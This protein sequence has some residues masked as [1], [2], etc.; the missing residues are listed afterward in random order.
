[1]LKR[2]TI[3]FLSLFA[4]LSVWAQ[5]ISTAEDFV[6][7]AQAISKGEPTTI[8]RNDDG[9]VCLLADIDMAKVRKFRGIPEFKGVFNG[10][11]FSIKNLKCTEP[12]FGR[13]EGGTV[14]N[15]T[16]DASCSMKLTD[17]DN[18]YGFIAGVNAGLIEDCVNY[19]KIEFKST[20]V[21]RRLVIGGIAGSNLHLVI[22]CRNYGHISAD[23]LSRTDSEKPAVSIGGIVG[24]NGGSR[25]ASCVAWSENSGTV[26]Y[27]G[28][29][30][31]DSVG[32]IVGDGNAGT[33]KFCVNR[34][35]VMSNASGSNGWDIYSRCA[36]IVGYTKGDVLCCDNFG[37]I[38]SQGNGIPSTAGVVGAMN[39]ADVI[40][41]CVN[42]GLVKVS[43]EREGSM[44]GICATV[45][46]SARVKSCLNYGDVV[47][48]GV[49]TKRRT[50]VGGIVGYLYN[51]KDAVTGGYIRDCA[52]Y[53]T[54]KSGKGG[55]RYENDD[56]A[57]HTGGI[58][59]YVRGSTAYR[60]ILSNCSNFGKV[61]SAGG[62]RGNIAGACQDVSIGG[63][64]INPYTES[65][66][67]TVA[68]H[69]VMGCVRSEDGTP[70]SG[71]LVSD[72][73]QT[74]Q[75][76]T[77]GYYLMKSDMDKIRFVYI[78]VPAAY[79]I[80]VSGSSPQF[81]R[82]VPRYQKAVKADF[83]LSPREEVNEKYT[84]LLVADPQI[85]PYAVDGSAETWRDD[86][87]T[88][89]NAYHATLTQ[90]CY[91]INLGDLIYNYPVAYDDYMDVAAGLKCPVFNVIGNHD[92]DQRNL[93]S[94]S[95][96]TPY[97]NVYTGPE[98]YSF[99]IGKIHYV[100]LNDII[101]D[102][103][104]AKDKYK[105][106]LE[107]STLEWLR[108]DL[109]FI[110][111][112]NTIVIAAHG[113]L[114]MSPK[115]NGLGNPNFE[116]YSDLLKDYAKVYCWAGHYHSNFGY[117]YAGK[118][119]GLDNIEAIC[120]SRATGSLRVNR[121]LN[122]HGTPQGYMVAEVDGIHM[123]WR[124]KAVGRT[125]DEQMTAYVPSEVDGKNVAVNVWNWNEDTWGV[126]EWWEN[127]RK[128]ADMESWRA[129]DPAYLK[130]I[131]DITDKYTL[132]LAQPA[133]SRYLFRA[134][135]SEGVTS[136]E[137]RVKDNFGNIFTKSITW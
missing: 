23:C 53:G 76:G 32:G 9:E 10:N 63:A 81:Y 17:G 65:A 75:T 27:I 74:V 35:E 36:G 79:Q 78:S 127:G 2:L 15:L 6:A 89:I 24:R 114:F 96:G 130:L 122:N 57:I 110:S 131:S 49:S 112:E 113:Q 105:V 109:Q 68:G 101:Y 90:E 55:N 16:I 102:R 111:K 104:S 38:S 54:V 14:R 28:D 72:G 34:G 97:F 103:T 19:G 100:V 126:P 40:L 67:V 5:G 73:F 123:S 1:M 25:W 116:K 31:Y 128:V 20:F 44:G 108:Q 93:Y 7:F 37:Y 92:F 59:G 85:R 13:I 48:E 95:L 69:N 8:W 135:P 94:T 86:V 91:A 47:Y 98:N 106:G 124:Y 22:R 118:G 3:S 62:R 77:D 41:D 43:N 80:P 18:L 83:V 39:D 42:Y 11:G 120:V 125:M 30:M 26:T 129:K 56:K 45:S 115:G 51:A 29:M 84:L 117:D 121:Y 12:I 136:G 52:N 71:V 66:E 87:A 88:D 132:E 119:I 134:L 60:V 82:R 4:A 61:E 58:A 21:S 50:S 133:I 70:I 107:E 137:I 33:V 46:R 64:Y 99:N